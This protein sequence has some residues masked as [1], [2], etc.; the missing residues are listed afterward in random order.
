MQMGV[1]DEFDKAQNYLEA[2]WLDEYFQNIGDSEASVVS[3]VDYGFSYLF[4]ISQ[5]R[6]IAA[7][8]ISKGKHQGARDASRMRGHPMSAGKSYHRGHAIAHTLGGGTDIN[9]VAQKG[10]V[11]IGAFR[12]LEHRAI[13]NPGS[14]YFTYWQYRTKNSQTP[15]GVDQGLLIP[16]QFADIRHFRN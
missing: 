7:W 3:T 10:A 5:G 1:N 16:R 2:V 15:T 8:G 14:L 4:D 13:A 6:L 11:N 12:Q 9:L